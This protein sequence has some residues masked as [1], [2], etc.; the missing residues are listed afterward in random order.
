M[1]FYVETVDLPVIDFSFDILQQV[2]L[3][4]VQDIT[5]CLLAYI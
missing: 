2:D 5:S 3:A 4:L 1:D